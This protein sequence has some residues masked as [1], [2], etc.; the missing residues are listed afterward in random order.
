MS[1][2]RLIPKTHFRS[3]RLVYV[4]IL[5]VGLCSWDAGWAQQLAHSSSPPVSLLPNFDRAITFAPTDR[6]RIWIEGSTNVSRFQCRAADVN[7]SGKI[8]DSRVSWQANADE[9]LDMVSK[10][11]ANI[12]IRVFSLDCGKARMNQDMYEALKAENHRFI[13]FKLEEAGSPHAIQ[14]DTVSKNDAW[15]SFT[16]RGT[17]EIAGV[18]KEVEVPVNSE[19]LDRQSLRFRLKGQHRLKMTTFEITPPTAL[20]GLVQAQNDLTVHFDLIVEPQPSP[21]TI[22]TLNATESQ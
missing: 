15:Y 12:A 10:P 3:S 1:P 22:P 7:G 14:T 8:S 19:L 20:Y 5:L 6:S 4:I 11:T 2:F 13:T 17:L 18:T 21:D 9:S 16:V